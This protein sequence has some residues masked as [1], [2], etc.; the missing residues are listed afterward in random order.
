[1]VGHTVIPATQEAEVVGS[2]L[3]TRLG[4]SMRLYLKNKLKTK[5]LGLG[6]WLQCYLASSSPSVQ[7]WYQGEKKKKKK[8]VL[9]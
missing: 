4:K 3:G 2:K 6:V 7:S 9:S 5:G 1:M 8:H